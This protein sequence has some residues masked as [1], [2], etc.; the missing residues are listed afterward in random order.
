MEDAESERDLLEPTDWQLIFDSLMA[1]KHKFQ[2]YPYP[3]PEYREKKVMEV[4]TLIEKIK[5][6]LR[7]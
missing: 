4:A 2:E 3:T 5:A 1:T 7:S 6:L